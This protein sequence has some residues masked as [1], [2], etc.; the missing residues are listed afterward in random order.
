MY[1]IL[2]ENKNVVA[3]STTQWA[4]WFESAPNRIMRRD[5][6]KDMNVSTVFLGLDHGSPG[7]PH[8]FE[9]M[10]FGG[11]WADQYCRRVGTYHEAQ[12]THAEVVAALYLGKLNVW[13]F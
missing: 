1:Y 13:E 12:N 2:D 5:K 7:N 11:T 6:V 9:T 8:L 10:V 3:V 4:Q